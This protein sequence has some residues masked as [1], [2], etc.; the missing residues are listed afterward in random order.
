[1]D[2]ETEQEQIEQ[3]LFVEINN[4]IFRKPFALI[5]LSLLESP[6]TKTDIY[7]ETYIT[8]SHLH[9]VMDILQNIGLIEFKRNGREVVVSLTEPGKEVAKH[10]KDVVDIMRKLPTSK[11]MK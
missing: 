10:L 9:K 8:Y 11:G 1:M 3:E 2:E 4:L 6:K 5:M 7:K